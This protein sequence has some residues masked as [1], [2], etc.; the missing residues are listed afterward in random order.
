MKI[1][2][3]RPVELGP[4]ELT[5][6]RGMQA[7]NV[8]L[9]N[10]FLS[11]DFALAV[12][13]MRR[14]ARIAVVE[15]TQGVVGFFPYEL[16]GWRVGR[17]IGTGFSDCQALVHEPGLEWNAR[18]LLRACG[19]GVWEFD[20]LLA[21]QAPFVPYHA[22]RERSAIIDLSDGYES[23]LHGRRQE[24]KNITQATFRKCRKL[25]R[26]VGDLRFDYDCRDPNILDTLMSWKSAQWRRTNQLDRFA[27]ASMATLVEEL[28]TTRTPECT[29]TL[30]VLSV[31]GRPLAAHFGLRSRTVLT[32]WFPSY[33]T[34]YSH[35][36]PGLLMFFM[37]AEA[38]A[39]QGIRHI[40]LGKGEMRYKDS[41]GNAELAVAQGWVERSRT[42]GMMR[43]ARRLPG[44]HLAS[45]LKEHPVL[46]DHVRRTLRSLRRTRG[47]V[48]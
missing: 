25:Q 11:V 33:D 5:S 15:E 23:Y 18:E 34:E 42:L 14:S 20:H 40:D 38:A 30:S 48:T 37:M 19:L 31:A 46:H 36:S 35:Y 1:S 22:A 43:R 28:F 17:A 47:S 2:I 7:R 29:G 16:C 8:A 9:R 10:P 41:L 32:S 6:W 24:R 3:L 13:R 4:A 39:A 21:D 27:N 26:E 12:G 44:Q 45:M